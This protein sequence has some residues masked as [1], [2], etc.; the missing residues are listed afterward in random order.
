MLLFDHKIIHRFKTK[1]NQV[2][3]TAQMI[4]CSW[5]TLKDQFFQKT[6]VKNVDFYPNLCE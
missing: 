3:H 1:Y 5:G 2:V 6:F 4:F